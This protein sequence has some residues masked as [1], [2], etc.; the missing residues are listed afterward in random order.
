MTK[1]PNLMT[2]RVK[3][4]ALYP[5]CGLNIGDIL[6]VA[7]DGTG[8]CYMVDI[9]LYH[10]S[11]DN[12]ADFPANF[13][14]LQWW[15]DRDVKD[16][17]EYLECPSRKTFHKVEKW[18]INSFIIDGR[19]KK[20]YINYIPSTKEDYEAYLQTTNQLKDGE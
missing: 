5:K 4:I 8:W 17:P 1:G 3:V 13:Q 20:H 15:E 9:G 16:M 10:N 7:E 6:Y 11:V 18:K 19:I 12:V 14:P 2:P